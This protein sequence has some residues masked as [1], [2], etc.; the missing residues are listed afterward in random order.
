VAP[1][2]DAGVYLNFSG[3]RF[4]YDPEGSLFKKVEEVYLCNEGDTYTENATT[5]LDINDTMTLYRLAV[6]QYAFE[7]MDYT[8]CFGLPV[9][10]RD[11]NGNV[12]NP[13]DRETYFIDTSADEGLQKLTEWMTLF[14]FLQTHFPAQGDG[15]SKTLY[16]ETGSA[17]G[18]VI[19]VAQ[20]E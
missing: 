18:R 6:N 20:Q 10:A 9:T 1:I 16:G 3:I 11:K 13:D 4:T 7:L 15:I 2:L 19:Q 17:M 12:I 8:S 14:E 5:L